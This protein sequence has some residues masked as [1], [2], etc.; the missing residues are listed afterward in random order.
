[1]ARSE[2]PIRR[3]ISWVR[4]LCL[5]FAAS[6]AWRVWVERGSIP[7]SAVTQPW[8]LP[9]RNGGNGLLDAG[10]AQHMRI[11]TAHQ[12]RAFRM[13]RE[14]AFEA[15]G[16]Q[17]I[18][19]RGRWVGVTLTGCASAA[20]RLKY[21]RWWVQRRRRP[22]GTRPRAGRVRESPPWSGQWRFRRR[23]KQPHT[24][25][26]RQTAHRPA[27][28][29]GATRGHVRQYR[30]TAQAAFHVIA[31]RVIVRLIRRDQPLA[32]QQLDM[33]VIAGPGGHRSLPQQVNPAVADMRPIGRALLHQAHGAGG[34][35]PCF[36]VADADQC[37]R[38]P[39]VPGPASGAGSPADRTR[40]A[41]C[42]RR[43][44][45]GFSV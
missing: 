4:P 22:Y 9:R 45:A 5:P 11:A 43:L 6:R 32:Q 26:C 13:A 40:A 36:P 41:G 15:D 27:A 12:H 16:P 34:A 39:R 2:R 3:C 8:P 20:R 28:A 24:R 25:R 33:A 37:A 35:R 44:P 23:A 14:P 42:A 21:C 10:R 19:G 18:G 38:L 31:H 29:P 1:M 7:Y 30:V 17:L